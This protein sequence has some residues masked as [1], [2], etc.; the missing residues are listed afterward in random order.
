[1][2][3]DFEAVCKIKFWLLDIYRFLKNICLH[4]YGEGRST[5]FEVFLAG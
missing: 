4:V 2:F 3:R 5:Q 1:L